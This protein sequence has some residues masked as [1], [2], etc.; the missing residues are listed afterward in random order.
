MTETV[1]FW[2][3]MPRGRVGSNLL[4]NNIKQIVGMDRCMLIN[5]NFNAMRSP[6]AQLAWIEEF[7][8]AGAGLD[9]IGCKQNIRTIGALDRVGSLLA[10]NGVRLVRLR[11]DN[12]LKVAISQL[13]AEL[14]A[15]R[16]RAET[17][18]ARWGV[19][20]GRLPLEPTPL[21]P[22]RF[23]RLVELARDTDGQLA[24]FA[25]DTPTLDIEYRQLQAGS[26]KVAA[27]VCHWLGL[28][29]SRR[30][31]PAFVKATPDNLEEAVPNLP[32]LREA[33][34]QSP[35]SDLAYM[36]DG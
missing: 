8:A 30:A 9:L 33:L 36:F 19:Y 13:R 7:Y 10:D 31:T 11:R 28:A 27:D 15:A 1:K 23:L 22:R 5:E 26:D 3:M 12:Y 29:V 2:M 18:V 24:R 21:D 25:P 34:N 17:G 35:L 6:E 16:S 14:Y 4:L 32:D 20:N